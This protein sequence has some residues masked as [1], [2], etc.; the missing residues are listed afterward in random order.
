MS[1]DIDRLRFDLSSSNEEA[2]F[3]A[4]VHAGNYGAEAVGLLPRLLEMMSENLTD[5]P[6][7]RWGE[8]VSVGRIL[9]AIES[10]RA[11]GNANDELLTRSEEA[12][13]RVLS[14]LDSASGASASLLVR[15]LVLVGPRMSEAA[16][17]VLAAALRDKDPRMRYRA[18]QFAYAVNPSLLT[19]HPWC[20]FAPEDEEERVKWQRAAFDP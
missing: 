20:T 9:H 6:T 10:L 5:V 13:N 8:F 3:W 1:N 7:R 17:A 12:I 15:I 14:F 18:Y 19:K 4:A 16:P 11:T 2:Q